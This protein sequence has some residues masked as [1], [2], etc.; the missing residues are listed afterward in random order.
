VA[1]H[2]TRRTHHHLAAIGAAG[3]LLAVALVG[4]LSLVGVT[5]ADVWPDSGTRGAPEVVELQTAPEKVGLA[6]AQ[7]LIVSTGVL[8]PAANPTPDRHGSGGRGD[9]R[10]PQGGATNPAPPGGGSSP[11]PPEEGIPAERV[12][13]PSLGHP[14]DGRDDEGGNG[15]DGETDD[16]DGEREAGR[17]DQDRD[18][19]VVEEHQSRDQGEQDGQ[20]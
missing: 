7:G 12:V 9:G 3:A 4:F 1:R 8:P 15:R 13:V 10:A 2:T 20:D 16:V 11:A 18:S 14:Q 19:V 17:G 6:E 5:T